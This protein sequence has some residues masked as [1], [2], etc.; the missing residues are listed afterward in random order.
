MNRRR[1]AVR[2]ALWLAWL[3][4]FAVYAC[5]L[6]SAPEYW[7]T[8]EMEVVPWI[9][10]IAHST[11]FPVF[12]ML[13]WLFAHVV[14]IGP[15]AGRIALFCALAMSLA[16]WLIARTIYLLEDE[17]WIATASAWLFA[18]GSVAWTRGTRAEVH[19]VAVAFAALTIFLA[20]R[21]YRTGDRSSLAGGALAWGLGI[22]THPIVALLFPA[23]L[24]LLVAR[25]HALRFRDVALSGALLLAGVSCYSY[26]PLRSAY[27]A[28]ARL[29]PTLQLGLPPG[30]PF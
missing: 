5:S 16:A 27:V 26:L 30:K 19:A 28:H 2:V 6:D 25:R 12:T 20:V 29:D 18:F 11:G 13:G 10:G 7:D 23:L 3:V 21:W 22:A 15:V 9:L 17:P 14:A 1:T 4:P 24:T 8:G